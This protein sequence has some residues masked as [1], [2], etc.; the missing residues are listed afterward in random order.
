MSNLVKGREN[1]IGK[2]HLC[3]GSAT[4]SCIAN[5]KASNSLEYIQRQ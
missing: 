1:V 2:L 3:N 4:S 5:S